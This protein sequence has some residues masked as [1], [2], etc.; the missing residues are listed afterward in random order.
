M[1]DCVA[2][3]PAYD[4]SLRKRVFVL[5]CGI[6]EKA[7]QFSIVAPN[8]LPAGLSAVMTACPHLAPC[9]AA[10]IF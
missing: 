10:A 2:H 4:P 6:E 8:L 1:A 5:S 7:K 9:L 3:K